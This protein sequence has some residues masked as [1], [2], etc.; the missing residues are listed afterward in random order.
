ME[1]MIYEIQARGSVRLSEIAR[2]VERGDCVEE[3]DRALVE[4]LAAFMN[5][6]C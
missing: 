6:R 4:T 5:K 1:E 2:F 3:D